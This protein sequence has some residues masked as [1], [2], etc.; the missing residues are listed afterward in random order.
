ML[1]N[2]K[3]TYNGVDYIPLEQ[4]LRSSDDQSNSSSRSGPNSN[5]QPIV[6]PR[7]NRSPSSNPRPIVT[8]IVQQQAPPENQ[9]QS[10]QH[11][12]GIKLPAP[13]TKIKVEPVKKTPI[14]LK[15]QED[16]RN[17][18]D[19]LNINGNQSSSNSLTSVT[20]LIF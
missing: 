4:F 1:D 8:R 15:M 20:S 11:E 12:V 14:L 19:D 6:M 7:Q 18:T 5:L 2:V 13:E 3:A 9:S 17:V 16:Q 10:Q